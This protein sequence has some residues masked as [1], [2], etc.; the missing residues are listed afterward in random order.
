MVCV[1]KRGGGEGGEG[2]MS[3]GRIASEARTPRIK[4][5]YSPLILPVSLSCYFLNYLFNFSLY[6]FFFSFFL[7]FLYINFFYIFKNILSKK[8]DSPPPPPT[9]GPLGLFW[10]KGRVRRG[11][12]PPHNERN[13]P[14]PLLGFLDIFYTRGRR[15]KYIFFFF[16]FSRVGYLF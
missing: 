1:E 6:N 16:V 9:G 12:T 14:P 15:G 10:D 4:M 5:V 2:K 11:P 7:V 8:K 3:R 13:S